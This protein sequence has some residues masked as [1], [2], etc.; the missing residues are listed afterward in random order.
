M[1]YNP[2]DIQWHFKGSLIHCGV[3]AQ[4]HD[5]VKDLK[6]GRIT[7]VFSLNEKAAGVARNGDV[8]PKGQR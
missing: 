4:G 6:T 2:E 5:V 7:R 3:S 1:D 8:I